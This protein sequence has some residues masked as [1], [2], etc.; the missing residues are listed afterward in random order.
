[1]SK[2]SLNTNNS[3]AMKNQGLI[4]GDGN[5]GLKKLSPQKSKLAFADRNQST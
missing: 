5:F 1:M 3:S 2:R 4:I